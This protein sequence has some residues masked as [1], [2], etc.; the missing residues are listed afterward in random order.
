MRINLQEIVSLATV[1]FEN[2]YV[3][4]T[5]SEIVAMDEEICYI[6]IIA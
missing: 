2:K 4:I 3:T 1:E 5:D 6:I